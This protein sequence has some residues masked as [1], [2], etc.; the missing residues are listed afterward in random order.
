MSSSMIKCIDGFFFN[1]TRF[2]KP[3]WSSPSLGVG[4]PSLCMLGELGREPSP[5]PPPFYIN[6]L[7]YKKIKT[8]HVFYLC[9][10]FHFFFCCKLGAAAAM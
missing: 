9:L 7:C 3:V 1:G 2:V 6:I 5:A 10:C 4:T 8:K